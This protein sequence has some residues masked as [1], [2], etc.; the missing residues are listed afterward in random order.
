M[1]Y[2]CSIMA[3]ISPVSPLLVITPYCLITTYRSF[4]KYDADV[5]RFHATIKSRN[6]NKQEEIIQKV[7]NNF[8]KLLSWLQSPLFHLIA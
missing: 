1:T 5:F 7:G 4:L 3:A 2:V 6:P 8:C